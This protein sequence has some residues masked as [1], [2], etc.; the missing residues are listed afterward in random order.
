[1]A[2]VDPQDLY[3]GLR[4]RGVPHAHAMGILAN[5]QAESGFDA[6]I[7]ERGAKRGRGGYG[8]CQWTGPR[9]RAL[10]R[11]AARHKA[12]VSDWR[13]QLDYLMTEPDT[14]RYLARRLPTGD[15]ATEWF[16]RYWERPAR[17]NL[18]TRLGYLAALARRLI[19][20]PDR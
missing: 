13:L 16:C 19:T 15:G 11:F 20:T 9:R 14:A 17:C 4:Q 18:K 1:M 3:D 5:M 6:G 12:E 10:E 7:Q 8:L 2:K